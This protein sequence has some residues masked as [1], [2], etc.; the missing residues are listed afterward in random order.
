V[1]YFVFMLKNSHFLESRGII[2]RELVGVEIFSNEDLGIRFISPQGFLIRATIENLHSTQRN[3]VLAPKENP[4]EA[5][6]L[7]EHCLAGLALLGIKNLD[8]KL[9][10]Y[11][12]P[13]GD[14]S[15]KLWVDFFQ[16]NELSGNIEASKF[17]LKE[18]IRIE[19]QSNPERFIEASPSE[20]FSLTYKLSW[21]H[22]K[23][24]K[25]SFTW[26]LGEPIDEIYL[27]RTFAS[28][29][30]NKILG[31]NNWVV[32]LT[33][34]DFSMPLHYP[35]EPARHKALDLIG[36]LMLSGFNPLE[37]KMSVLSNQGGH[38]LNSK[39]ALELSKS[40]FL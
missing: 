3:T 23:I 39:L 19:D 32:G 40:V 11:E 33:E 21:K 22:P 30:E 6:C 18:T 7:T 1:I 25:Q 17:S 27:A 2:S 5:I 38:E 34:D 28:E 16:E 12:L 36:D 26:T 37:V 13:F 20:T 31:L 14:G 35:D 15:S 9:N 4:S 29:E 10:S 24:S 8:I